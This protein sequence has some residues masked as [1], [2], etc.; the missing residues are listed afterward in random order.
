MSN[1]DHQIPDYEITLLVD[2]EFDANSG[3]RA[4]LRLCDEPERSWTTA[5]SRVMLDYLAVQG[6]KSIAPGKIGE[7]YLSAKSIFGN[8]ALSTIAEG[9]GRIALLIDSD[10]GS[11]DVERYYK[12]M[13]KTLTN[14]NARTEVDAFV[15]GHACS[16]GFGLMC[17]AN[18]ISV[19]SN[20]ILMWH[21]SDDGNNRRPKIVSRL[22]KN[23]VLRRGYR[24]ELDDLIRFLR[25]SRY[26]RYENK[27]KLVKDFIL[28]SKD[29][30]G[31]VYFRGDYA[32]EQELVDASYVD[33]IKMGRDYASRYLGMINQSV[34]DFWVISKLTASEAGDR[35]NW[36][37]FDFEKARVRARGEL[38]DMV[39]NEALEELYGG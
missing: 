24:K 36:R 14:A 35:L 28:D 16:A 12:R 39:R 5:K 7:A 31:E 6:N 17:V 22:E 32:Y 27:E 26:I 18:G 10:G 8:K 30:E 3:F 34:S 21:F 29:P 23:M 2:K 25:R 4:D 9:R 19:L 33:P 20:S 37:N 11:V 15:L 38:N 1:L 13:L